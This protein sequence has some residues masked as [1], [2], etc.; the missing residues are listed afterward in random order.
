MN[1]L[2]RIYLNSKE[3]RMDE[4]LRLSEMAVRYNPGNPN[5]R[6][7]LAEILYKGGEFKKALA[8]IEK[9]GVLD[10]K[11]KDK[12]GKFREAVR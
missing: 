2:A 7:T 1:T 12:V 4:A 9:A 11:F 5:Y 8:E 6:D 10:E 3:D